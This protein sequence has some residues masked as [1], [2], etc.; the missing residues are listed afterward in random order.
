MGS[1]I[2][3][4]MYVRYVLVSNELPQ[5]YFPGGGLKV[6]RKNSMKRTRFDME[7]DEMPALIDADVDTEET[8]SRKRPK[9]SGADICD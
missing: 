5:F 8:N 9:I 1:F 6:N 4:G 7:S 3:T 2:D